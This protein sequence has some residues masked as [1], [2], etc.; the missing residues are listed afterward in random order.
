MLGR[1]EAA[2][3]GTRSQST[4]IRLIWVTPLAMLAATAANLGLYYASGILAPEVLA[5][6]G[7]GPAQIAGANMIYLLGGAITLAVIARLSSRPR[8]L[9]VIAASIG[10]LVSLALPISAGLGYGPPGTP[11]AGLATVISLSL[12]HVVSYAISVPLSIRYVLA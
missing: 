3:V 5:W 10:L 9:Y 11:P 6:P 7:A 4:L 12:M 2:T 8:R 1:I